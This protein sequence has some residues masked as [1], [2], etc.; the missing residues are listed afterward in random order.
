VS[1][2]FDIRLATPAD[3]PDIRALV[4]SVAMPGDVAVR[5]ARE[6]DYFCGTTIM[7]DPCDVLVGRRMP[8]GAL[9]GIAC[10]AE[11]QAFVSGV[12]SPLGY[13]GQ[14]RI[15]EEF[16][17]RWLVPR[18]ARFMRELSPPGLLYF[19]VIARENPRAAGALVGVRPPAGIR[20]VRV[21][22]IT[23]CAIVLRRRRAVRAPGVTVRPASAETLPDVVAF[24]RAEGARR[25]FFPAYTLGD[26]T[27]GTAL[28][29]LVAEDVLVAR[30]TDRIVGVI[31]VWDQSAYKQDV[32]AA[33]GPALRRARPLYDLAARAV[34]ARPLTPPGEAI[35][36]AFAACVCVADDD[37]D[38]MRMLVSAATRAAYEGGKA[39]LMVG[40][41]DADPLLAAA[42]AFVHFT[43][44]SDLYALS[45]DDDPAARLDG[46]VPYIE[47][48]TL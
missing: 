43:Y 29:G 3:E 37:P 14:I 7:G 10:R 12:E 26:F 40:L 5:F 17:G 21:S 45:F 35:P 32:V 42:R 4:G 11:R 2:P 1:G 27:G 31:A 30:R 22:G 38:V 33:Y 6:P 24:L 48:A 8:D 47:I 16:R 46:R 20:A 23:T 28:R 13:I 36:L 25:Q 44:R 18:G 34:G 15:A 41:A 9:A 19:G 39:Y